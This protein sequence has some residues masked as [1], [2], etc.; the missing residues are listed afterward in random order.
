MLWYIE[1]AAARTN[2]TRQP[3]TIAASS[4]VGRWWPVRRTR[5]V[6]HFERPVIFIPFTSYGTG[7]DLQKIVGQP[8]SIGFQRYL[9]VQEER[10]ILLLRSLKQ[11]L[12]NRKKEHRVQVLRYLDTIEL[13][14]SLDCVGCNFTKKPKVIKYFF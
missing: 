9:P 14:L 5:R 12:F 1:S 11:K 6:C 8:S 4:Y 7:P 10:P 3:P 2:A 13:V